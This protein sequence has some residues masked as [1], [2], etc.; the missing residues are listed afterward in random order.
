MIHNHRLI[1][2][3][4]AALDSMTS[5]EKSIAQFF[6]ETDL[7]VEELTASDMIKRL[8]V[9]QAALTRFAKKCGFTGY[10]EFVFECQKSREAMDQKAP[11]L[12][13]SNTKKVL[14]NYRELIEKATELI[15]EKQLQ[16]IAQWIENAERIYFYGKGSSA[17]AAKEFKLR[18]MRL[19]VICEALDDTDSFTWVNSS[20]T[21]KCLVIGFSL[22]AQTASV[23]EALQTAGTR[24]A[25]TV[26]LTTQTDEIPYQLDEIVHIATARHLNYGNRI[27]PQFPMLFVTDIIY[28]Y[29]LEINKE[30]KTK[31]FQDTIINH[32][33]K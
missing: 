31:I 26:L 13:N 15:N 28:A 23:L 19:G 27:S 9:S 11:N 3:M 1:S 6:M 2:K 21:D 33:D 7:K 30:G 4:E 24:G 8:H 32:S 5:L 25:K 22:S 29:F 17:L 18:L 14:M 12:Q 20:I 16:D 10:R